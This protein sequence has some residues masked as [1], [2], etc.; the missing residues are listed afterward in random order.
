MSTVGQGATRGSYGKGMHT[1]GT[2]CSACTHM[3]EALCGV[4]EARAA[5]GRGDG[6]GLGVRE[7]FSAGFHV[8]RRSQ[9]SEFQP[10]F[11]VT[12]EVYLARCMFFFFLT[13]EH[14]FFSSLLQNMLSIK[15]E[16]E[17]AIFP[18]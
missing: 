1:A 9:R 5:K 11:Q 4:G 7:K 10:G 15:N 13:K 2:S 12:V 3:L 18:S 8:L 14:L 16:K 6:P 17:S